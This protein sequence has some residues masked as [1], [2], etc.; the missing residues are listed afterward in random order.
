MGYRSNI[1]IYIVEPKDMSLQEIV[2]KANEVEEMGQDCYETGINSYGERV[3][4]VNYEDVEWESGYDIVEYWNNI[5]EIV[6]E[7]RYLFT[8]AGEENNDVEMYGNYGYAYP[9]TK[10]DYDVDFKNPNFI[11]NNKEIVCYV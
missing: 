9:V 10:F 6:G 3:L 8:R 1:V 4:K 7:D 5:M 2:R 11:E